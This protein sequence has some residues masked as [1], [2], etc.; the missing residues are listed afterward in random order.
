MTSFRFAVL[1]L[2]RSDGLRQRAQPEPH[3]DDSVHR[4]QLLRQV[5]DQPGRQ[6]NRRRRP[7]ANQDVGF[8]FRRADSLS[9]CQADFRTPNTMVMNRPVVRCGGPRR[10][11]F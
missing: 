6:D 11:G 10:T 5:R 8:R 7:Q 9:V 3:T 1:L 4:Q 2:V